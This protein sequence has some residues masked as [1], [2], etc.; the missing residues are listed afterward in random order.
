MRVNGQN[1]NDFRIYVRACVVLL[2]YYHHMMCVM[3]CRALS[4]CSQV[5]SGPQVHL[6]FAVFCF[7]NKYGKV[8]AE[9]EL[10]YKNTHN[11]LQ[12]DGAVPF[13]GEEGISLLLLWILR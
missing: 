1:A 7:K 11:I 2:Y 8:I 10:C 4:R 12:F 3:G 6:P 9:K 5:C 13:A